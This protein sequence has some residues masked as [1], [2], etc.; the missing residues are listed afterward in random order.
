[1]PGLDCTCPVPA[2]SDDQNDSTADLPGQRPAP[3]A[4]PTEDP[5]GI[6]TVRLRSAAEFTVRPVRWVW[7]QRIPRGEL[8]L[9]AGREG[10]GKST[11]AYALAADLTRGRLPGDHGGT[12]RSVAV[13]AT[14]DSW[15]HTIVPRLM[16]ADADLSR[17]FRVEVTTAAGTET[18]LSLPRDLEA[19]EAALT[20]YDVALLLLDPL[21]SRLG[22][23]LDTHKDAEVRQALE[24]LVMV[25]QR[26]GTAVVGLI[27]VNKGGGT[28]PL[29]AVMA[30]RAFVAVA[31]A[32]LFVMPDPDND[33][34]RLLGL[35][36]SNLGPTDLPTLTFTVEA[37]HV[38]D[39][40]DGPVYSGTVVWGAE[41]GESI[42][43][44]M[45][46][47][48]EST[49][50][51]TAVGEARDWLSDFLISVGGG[52]WSAEIIE[53]GGRAGHSKDALKRARGKLKVSSRGE[54]FPRQ[55]WWA[56]PGA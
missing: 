36:K 33:A 25:G 17:V 50:I 43:E 47:S 35:P 51:R 11:V 42:R 28:D 44:A 20:E 30:S 31:R 8:T 21:V 54:G 19:T 32:V 46:A 6:R 3:E 37:Q 7:D 34:V 27:H 23:T 52:A 13:A 55:T 15:E 53:A 14:E 49:E 24:P 48:S 16:A 56:L 29:T 4:A 5:P 2:T 18:S 9:L 22:A 39:T 45:E 10:I 41:R 1:M 40:A 38:A 12:P 26:T